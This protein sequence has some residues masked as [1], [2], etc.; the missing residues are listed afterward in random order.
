MVGTVPCRPSRAKISSSTAGT[1]S[2]RTPQVR[3]RFLFFSSFFRSLEAMVAPV[4]I[5]DNGVFI[6]P[7]APM[8]P[9]RTSG[10]GMR[11]R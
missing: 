3:K 1:P 9:V 8:G 6:S 2:I 7:M 4:M 11:A 5:M 10:S